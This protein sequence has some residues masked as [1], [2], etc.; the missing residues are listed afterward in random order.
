MS[1]FVASSVS[2]IC[3]DLITQLEMAIREHGL[4]GQDFQ[5]PEEPGR[6]F[7]RSYLLRL[8]DSLGLQPITVILQAETIRERGL[9]LSRQ[10][11]FERAD[12]A[13][14]DAERMCEQA[15]V[16]RHAYAAA[17]TF[18]SAA[19][20]YLAYRQGRY[21]MAVNLLREALEFSRVLSNDFGH[22]MEFRK[23][24]LGRNIIRAQCFITSTIE[25]IHSTV[26]L[27]AYI[28]GNTDQWPFGNEPSW[29]V[30][31]PLT[32]AELVWSIDETITN[33]TLPVLQLAQSSFTADILPE[34]DAIA[35]LNHPV[36][37][38]A[39]EWM[40]AL[41]AGA[42]GK[43]CEM[44]AHAAAYFQMDPGGL[45]HARKAMIDMLRAKHFLDSL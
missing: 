35:K 13:L 21:E 24:H 10:G 36:A 6:G 26:K 2:T 37:K 39:F 7:S 42:N 43:E 25:V 3:P 8:S 17:R 18:Q 12:S 5:P 33:L 16:P 14:R 9:A 20:A 38:A 23:V 4:R 29:A 30:K 22:D 45:L 27:V 31:R 32:Q 40:R 11:D 1:Q 19:E 41:I 15:D 44:I 34:I 28:L